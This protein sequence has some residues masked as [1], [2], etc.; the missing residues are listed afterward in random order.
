MVLYNIVGMSVER[1]LSWI[2]LIV[3]ECYFICNLCESR[4]ERKIDCFPF[5]PSLV[6]SYIILDTYLHLWHVL[7]PLTIVATLLVSFSHNS[8]CFGLWSKHINYARI[9]FLDFCSQ[10]QNKTKTQQNKKTKPQ[11]TNKKKKANNKTKQKTE[12]SGMKTDHCKSFQVYSMI[13]MC[14]SFTAHGWK[15]CAQKLML[16]KMAAAN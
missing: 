14:S 1:S 4:I 7:P 3:K 2:Y 10:K 9:Y 6:C 11:K 13:L 12:K 16:A 5:F 8:S 15:W